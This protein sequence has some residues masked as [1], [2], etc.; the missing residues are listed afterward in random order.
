MAS[1]S[2]LVLSSVLSIALVQIAVGQSRGVIGDFVITQS[3]AIGT[4]NRIEWAA[5]G[6]YALDTEGRSL[7]S[8]NGT[9]MISDPVDGVAWEVD[10]LD[11]VAY[12]QQ[13]GRSMSADKTEISTSSTPLPDGVSSGFPEPAVNGM[14]TLSVV[15]LGTREING[16]MSNGR[17]WTAVIPAGAIGNVNPIEVEAEMWTTDR[18]GETLPVLTI[19]RDA[20]NGEYR[21]EL[22]NIRPIEF[23]DGYFRPAEELRV[24]RESL[25]APFSQ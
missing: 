14:E 17:G 19:S 3:K 15:D 7:V 18:F 12:E 9:T 6:E 23:S 10:P 24:E 1:R 20:V 21:R 2:I 16:V 5:T 22:R 11:G 4:D 25:E 8:M 13:M